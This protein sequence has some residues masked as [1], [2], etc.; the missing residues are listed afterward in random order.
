MALDLQIGKAQYVT[1]SLFYTEPSDQER[2]LQAQMRAQH[3]RVTP[4]AMSPA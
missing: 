1:L 2:T 4:D 3:A